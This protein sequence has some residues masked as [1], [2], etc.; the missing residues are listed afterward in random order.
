MATVSGSYAEETLMCSSFHPSSSD[1]FRKS[2]REFLKNLANSEIFEAL[3]F[4]ETS[5]KKSSIDSFRKFLF[6]TIIF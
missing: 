3:G 1:F 2:S 6:C 5:I 4:S